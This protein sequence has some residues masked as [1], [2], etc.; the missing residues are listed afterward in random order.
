MLS[1]ITDLTNLPSVEDDEF[2]FKSS[3]T[4]I[5]ELGKKLACAASGFA[6][7]GGGIFVAGVDGHGD[8]DGGLPTSI[9][10]QVL[11]DWVDQIIHQVEPTPMY[12]LNLFEDSNG[13]GSINPNCSVLVVAFK[14]SHYGP[15]MA[16]DHRYYI[17]AGAHTVPARH[18]I[19]DS[20]WAKRHSAKPRLIHTFRV[21]PENHQ[22]VQLGIVSLTSVPAIDVEI[23]ISP[24][25]ELLKDLADYF[26]LF[27]P[28]IDPTTPFYFDVSTWTMIKERFGENVHLTLKYLDLSGNTYI[29]EAELNI[30]R[31]FGP[32]RF[33]G[34]ADDK[35][36]KALES[37]EKSLKKAIK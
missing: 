1:N 17:R 22:V 31:S 21:K 26:P 11:R 19:V 25:G 6:N 16:P 8:A 24:L 13:R 20:L 37:I 32:M 14:E 15:H 18:F 23:S 35:I 10:R 29:Y 30:E 4:P 34:N 36:V 2:E 9:G 27:V 12:E 7:S 3:A 33:G 28:V 5:S